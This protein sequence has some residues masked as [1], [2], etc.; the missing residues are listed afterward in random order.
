MNKRFNWILAILIFVNVFSFMGCPKEP[1]INIYTVTFNANGGV[2][3]SD[4]EQ[5]ILAGGKII[6]PSAPTRDG[7][8]F[9]GWYTDQYCTTLFDINNNYVNNNFT[10]YAG[11]NRL[12]YTITFDKKQ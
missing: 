4:A 6:N 1:E 2:L 12:V 11:W 10:L 8:S 9:T 7:Y 3:T 5:N